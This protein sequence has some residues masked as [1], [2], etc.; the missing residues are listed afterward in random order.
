MV[1]ECLSAAMRSMSRRRGSVGTCHSTLAPTFTG[2]IQQGTRWPAL[3]LLSPPFGTS[4]AIRRERRLRPLRPALPNV[5]KEARFSGSRD[6]YNGASRLRAVQGRRDWL[7][8]PNAPRC[9]SRLCS[10][11]NVIERFPKQ[12]SPSADAVC[13]K[14]T[15]GHIVIALVY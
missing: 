12:A 7:A 11:D 14:N 3:L 9:A 13:R 8:S 15:R 6:P 10:S 4:I 2:K 5:C 1:S